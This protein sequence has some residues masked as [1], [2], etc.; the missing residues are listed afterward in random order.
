MR[1]WLLAVVVALCAAYPT[2]GRAQGVVNAAKSVAKAAKSVPNTLAKSGPKRLPTLRPVIPGG[3][4]SAVAGLGDEAAVAASTVGGA[5]A[6]ALESGASGSA[7]RA[8]VAE[9]PESG[10]R[11]AGKNYVEGVAQDKVK[12]LFEP[13]G[14]PEDQPKVR[15]SA[16]QVKLLKDFQRSQTEAPADDA[17]V[18]PLGGVVLLAGIWLWSRRA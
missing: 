6:P 13:E 1:P 11:E 4:G 14:Q 16:S 17:W 9:A 7:S 18:Y 3:P 12:E 2:D 10:L 5:A 15:L 8:A